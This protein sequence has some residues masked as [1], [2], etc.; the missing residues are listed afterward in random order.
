MCIRSHKGVHA[1]TVMPILLWGYSGHS[2]G[3]TTLPFLVA[4]LIHFFVAFAFP[5]ALAF[6]AADRFPVSAVSANTLNSEV[7]AYCDQM[8]AGKSFLD[9][10]SRDCVRFTTLKF[11]V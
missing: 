11:A 10:P 3:H 4:S 9:T 6:A 5:L 8:S 7:L 1:K 2:P